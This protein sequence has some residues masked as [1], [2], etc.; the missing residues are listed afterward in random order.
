M[1]SEPIIAVNNVPKSSVWYQNFLGCQSIHG[2]E[3]FDVLVGADGEVLLCLHKW[4]AHNHPSMQVS[5]DT[6]EN[7]LI[8][9]F[10]V[11]DLEQIRENLR[12]M[13][14]PV[15]DEIAWSPNSRKKEFTLRDLDGY[16][17]TVAEFHNYKG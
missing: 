1:K 12:L 6:P 3:E 14:H 4:G 15:L 10:R 5:G 17:I 2:G 11:E 13:N 7:G 9:Y 16:Y 8:L